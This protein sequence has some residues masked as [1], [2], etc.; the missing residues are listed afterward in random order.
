MHGTPAIAQRRAVD[1][2]PR[3][4]R[5]QHTVCRVPSCRLRNPQD[6]PCLGMNL[7]LSTGFKTS[8]EVVLIRQHD[9]HSATGQGGVSIVR[10]ISPRILCRCGTGLTPNLKHLLDIVGGDIILPGVL[11]ASYLRRCRLALQ[12]KRVLQRIER[13]V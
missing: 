11:G 12:W 6:V 9:L 13:E 2:V 5:G 7:N 10:D 1:A 4:E 3:H 8:C